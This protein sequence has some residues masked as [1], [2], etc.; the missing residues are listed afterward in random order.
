VATFVAIAPVAGLLLALGLPNIQVLFT[1]WWQRSS[2]RP[3]QLAAGLAL[4][5][6]VSGIGSGFDPYAWLVVAAFC[7]AVLMS[8]RERSSAPPGYG[9][10]L[11]WLML[12]VPFD[13]RLTR[14]LWF[15]AP[16]ISYIWWSLA[17]SV[18]LVVIWR[19]SRGLPGLSMRL[20]PKGRDLRVALVA[21]LLAILTL[22]PSGLAVGFISF[23]PP[24]DFPWLQACSKFVALLF[25]V[26]IPEELFFRGV[27]MM[28]LLAV[29]KK[30]W[31]S[32][33][34]SSLLFGLFHWNNVDTLPQQLA[35]CSLAAIAGFIYA[36]AYLRS[37]N[38]LLAAALTH[39]WVD[40]VWQMFFP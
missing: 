23:N 24:D 36:Q 17:L 20:L 29:T 28:A 6:L 40:W 32:V 27:L 30:L 31:L 39:T 7:V 15:G 8:A 4:C 3:L 11:L 9:D 35:Y 21:S 13:Y 1:P 19:D 33:L 5:Y 16:G 18:L 37:G 38:N 2:R 26:A 14:Q 34:L 25:T 22:V 12:L 10:L